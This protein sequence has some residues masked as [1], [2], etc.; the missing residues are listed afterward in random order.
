MNKLV[1]IVLL[2]LVTL[3]AQAFSNRKV[4]IDD[5]LPAGNIVVEKM[6]GDT[7]YVQPDLTGNREE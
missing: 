2:A 7:V 6:S 1:T 4:R 5:R 3:Q